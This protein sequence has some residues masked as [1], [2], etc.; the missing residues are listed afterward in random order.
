MSEN[1]LVSLVVER[2]A[3]RDIDTLALRAGLSVITGSWHPVT[4][5]EYVRDRGEIV[6]NTRSEIGADR[7]TAHEL[8]HHF[9][10]EYGLKMFD[11][12]GFCDRFANALL[13]PNYTF[14]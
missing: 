2:F 13:S 7:V 5:G 1:E 12:E 14:E 9:V 6:V 3:T 10:Q 4:A 11:E 8:G